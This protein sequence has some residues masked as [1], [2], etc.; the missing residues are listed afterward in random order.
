[1]LGR[2]L[3]AL[4]A[5]CGFSATA[6]AQSMASGLPTFALA[7]APQVSSPW[8]GLYVGTGLFAVSGNGSK[9]HVGGDLE[10][11]YSHEFDNR[12]VL[13]VREIGGFAPALFSQG[14]ARGFDFATTEAVVG[15][16][17]GRWM[18]YITSGVA[19]VKPVT[20][21]ASN[22]VSPNQ[23]MNDLFAAPGQL[24]ALPTVGAGVD[25]AITPNLHV[26]ASVTTGPNLGPGLR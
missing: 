21:A 3:F 12:I 2:S 15:Y 9:A 1:M 5:F 22:F 4:I 7:P 14:P 20:G 19:L 13:G 25:Y 18:P 8:T 6:E 16:D 11:G 23:S 17:M 26:G 10:I 24:H